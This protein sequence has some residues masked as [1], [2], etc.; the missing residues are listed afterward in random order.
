MEVTL[1]IE[2]VDFVESFG[3]LVVAGVALGAE[4]ARSSGQRVGV[5]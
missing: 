5:Q 2:A 3:Y 1:G 4:L